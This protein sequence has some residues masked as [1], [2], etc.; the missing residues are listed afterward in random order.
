MP[1]SLTRPG[2][3]ACD[4]A[5]SSHCARRERRARPRVEGLESRLALS[6][7]P[8][9]TQIAPVPVSVS[10]A[11]TAILNNLSAGDQAM[12]AGNRGL[13]LT[14]WVN[15]WSE[16]AA[17]Q[18]PVGLAGVAIR[19]AADFNAGYPASYAYNQAI[20][21]AEF[22]TDPT[23]G[24]GSGASLDWGTSQ[25]QAC[26]SLSGVIT[27]ALS[28]AQN[29]SDISGIIQSS[30]NAYSTVLLP[31]LVQIARG[32]PPIL[33]GSWFVNAEGVGLSFTLQQSGGN[34]TGVFQWAGSPGTI[35]GSGLHPL[36]N[37]W[38]VTNFTITYS[39][40]GVTYPGIIAESYD[41]SAA[42]DIM[43]YFNNSW[44]VFE[45]DRTWS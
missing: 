28:G 26:I 41:A 13:A 19:L 40:N 18:Y 20:S 4:E 10:Q 36:Q 45:A 43:F 9:G 29:A 16:A 33:A 2:W 8:P 38:Y 32:T 42:M 39:G 23:R 44:Y 11:E 34:W 15:A 7:P 3:R 37:G 5:P 1:Q 35:T 14:D 30:Q 24:A 31:L 27:S 21:A 17:A 22:W 6:L 12:A 25:L